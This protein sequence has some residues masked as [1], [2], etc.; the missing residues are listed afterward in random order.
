MGWLWGSSDPADDDNKNKDPL[1]GLDPSLRDFLKK[2]SPV[3]YETAT[4]Q[5]HPAPIPTPQPKDSLSPKTQTTSSQSTSTSTSKTSSSSP[6]AA[7][8][9]QVPSQSLYKDGRYAHLWKTYESQY[10]VENANKT[11]QEKINDVL[12]GYKYRKHEIGKA[13][14]EN[15]ALE[16]LEVNYCFKNGSWG[17]R[18]TMCRKENREFERCY[19]MQAKF[20]KAL[21]YL[22]TFDRP[23]EVDEQIQMHADTLYHRMLDQERAVA[24]AKASN[25]PPPVFAPLLSS[26]KVPGAAHANKPENEL[27]PSDLPEKV[28]VA[29]KKRL[30]GLSN[31]E[32]ELEE[33]AIKAEIQAGVEVAKNLGKLYEVQKEE[34]RVRKE[35]GRE[36]IGDKIAS[37]LGFR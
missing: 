18:M 35:M 12:E 19:T 33:R 11:D 21:G 34:R 30:E 5:S 26:S 27:Q 8:E 22:S 7:N 29:F 4:S 9:T 24:D 10:E 1:R 14:L 17:S 32:R 20:L 23:P 6:E 37:V 25:T 13:A 15:C 2:E 16:Q 31:E 3:K 36:T 28:Q